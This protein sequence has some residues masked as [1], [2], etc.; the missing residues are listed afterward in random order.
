[1]R[2]H[3]SNLMSIP[4]LPESPI[5]GSLWPALTSD[6]KFRQDL[7]RYD[8]DIC[9]FHVG[10]YTFVLVAQRDMCQEVLLHT[11][12]F[13]KTPAV[14]AAARPA[15]GTG[16]LLI[17]NG[18]H[19]ARRRI[20]QPAFNHSSVSKYTQT[21]AKDAFR[22]GQLW[23]DGDVIDISKEMTALTMR[24]IGKVM[25]DLDD[26]GDEDEL[27][28]AITTTF[29]Y[30]KTAFLLPLP[31][32]VPLPHNIRMRHALTL[33][34]NMIFNTINKQRATHS[35]KGDLLSLLLAAHDE[36]GQG[37]TDEQIR[38]DAM[39]ILVAGHETTA[40]TL[41]F[42]FY[43]LAKNPT[44]YAKLRNEVKTV[45]Q[46]RPPTADDLTRLPFTVQVFKETLRLFPAA[47][48]LPRQAT[49]D[50]SIGDYEVRRGWFVGIDVW[51]MHRRPDY[52]PKPLRFD[53]DRFSPEREAQIPRNAYIPFGSGPRNCI[54]RGLAMME[55]PLILAS[56]AQQVQL[57]LEPA[58]R[59]KLKFLLTIRPKTPLIMRVHRL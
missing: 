22:Q 29:D 18:P 37:L 17:E 49:R 32:S 48:S 4:T 20:I 5:V 30:M 38:D 2:N 39:A 35:E 11:E 16:I 12:E 28:R 52:F 59:L 21:I 53:P 25:F 9:R 41:A 43:L 50:T 23:A 3:E 56:L 15:F 44:V 51:G 27:G 57:E 24:I 55:G 26:L 13:D 47:H 58:T 14:T 42:A 31:L 6:T 1:M 19:R 46:G 33:L 8:P 40:Y 10:P 36:N 7:R 45:L 54:G 34:D